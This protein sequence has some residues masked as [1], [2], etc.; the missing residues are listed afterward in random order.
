ML[1][2][3]LDPDQEALRSVARDFL[4]TAVSGAASTVV[5]AGEQREAGTAAGLSPVLWA[6]MAGLGWLGL[7]LPAEVGGGG[8]GLTTLCALYGELGRALAPAP[9][10]EV[11][12]IAAETI[13]RAGSA[14]QRAAILPELAAGRVIVLPALVDEDGSGLPAHPTVRARA[15]VAGG[16]VLSGT[17]P[18]VPFAE[19]ADLLL[20]PAA[21]AGAGTLFLVRTALPGVTI[22][23]A[24][25]MTGL[26]VTSVVLDNVQVGADAVLGAPGQA[27]E[28][29]AP[30][31]VRGK[32]LRCA[33]IAGAGVCVLELVLAYAREREQF[34][35]PI[36]R[37][38]AVQYLCTDLA[39]ATRVTQLLTRQAAWLLDQGEQSSA[40]IAAANAY[41]SAAAR[42]IAHCAHEVF[43]GLG[44]MREHDLHL[45]S[46]RLK[47]WEMD[48]G[49]ASFH[50][51]QLA[52]QL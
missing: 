14:E 48:L 32:L 18:L 37:Y 12:V 11:S 17:R 29:L 45:F 25:S 4:R 42:Q 43:A 5:A 34:G 2:S 23:P 50:S 9:C 38:Q 16:W 52:A 35:G 39:I 30:V 24:P 20:V 47:Y 46:R 6:R 36:G 41:G 27:G 26:P 22:T 33:E 7:G 13:L 44:F 49:D 19:S 31:I 28:Y 40:R 21:A 15:G 3:A 8:A 51:G 10:L 1:D